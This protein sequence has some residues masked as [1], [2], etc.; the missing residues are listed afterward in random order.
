MKNS[1]LLPVT[2][3]IM[4]LSLGLMFINRM[5]FPMPDWVVRSIGIIMLINLAA[6]SY[7]TAK[8]A[9]HKNQKGDMK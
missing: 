5:I 3:V 6:L 9:S 8:L 7:T 1:Y 2:L 4:T